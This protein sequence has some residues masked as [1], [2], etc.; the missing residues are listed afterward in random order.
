MS[1]AAKT[2]T[3]VLA[4]NLVV[5][6][7]VYFFTRQAYEPR[8]ADTSAGA[9]AEQRQ[10]TGDWTDRVTDLAPSL[11]DAAGPGPA[12]LQDP[13]RISELANEAFAARDYRRA[14]E[15]YERLLDFDPG[16]ADVHNN[17]GLTL[18]Y[19]GRSGEALERL[20]RG[21]GIDATNQ[22]IWLTLGFVNG[23]LGNIDEARAALATAAEMDAT[24]D[25]GRSA[26]R[27][28]EDMQPD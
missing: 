16:N 17:L 28:L 15:L 5:A 19:L 18:H 23:Q 9:P 26:R 20:E 8:R 11:L 13:A 3:L 25:V 22:R 24:S 10:L 21:K 14:A 4:S 1:G 6:L 2:W 12:A 7:A 27:M